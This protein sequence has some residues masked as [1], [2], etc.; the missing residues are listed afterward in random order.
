MKPIMQQPINQQFP[1]HISAIGEHLSVFW[2]NSYCACAETA[3]SELPVILTRL[4]LRLPDFLYG[5]D[6]IAIG[7]HLP[8]DLDR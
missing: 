1:R 2:P 8:H 5:V 6:V 4:W 7:E 3:I